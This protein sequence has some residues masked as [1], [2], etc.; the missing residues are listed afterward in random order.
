MITAVLFDMNDVLYRYNR[1]LRVG[2]LAMLCG[3]AGAEVEAAIWE[4]GFEDSGDA[5]EMD[6]DGYLA[7]FKQ[8]L[9]C[10]LTA[11]QWADALE[12]SQWRH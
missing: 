4:S 8:Q 6:A 3:K 1:R 2:R 10:E 7:G 9:G 12:M 5:G 11:E